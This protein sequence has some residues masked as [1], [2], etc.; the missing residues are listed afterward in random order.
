MSKLLGVAETQGTLPS[1]T[2]DNWRESNNN[3]NNNDDNHY[4]YEAQDSKLGSI[5][6]GPVEE[7]NDSP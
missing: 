6:F 4:Y 2:P 7:V 5:V 1:R 3:D